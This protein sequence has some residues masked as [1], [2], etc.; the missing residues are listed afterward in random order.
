MCVFERVCVFENQLSAQ[1]PFFF[2]VLLSYYNCFILYIIYRTSNSRFLDV[3]FVCVCVCVCARLYTYTQWKPLPPR[4]WSP[5]ASCRLMP[6]AGQRFLSRPRSLTL[7]V[8]PEAPIHSFNPSSLRAGQ[9]DARRG[10]NTVT[11]LHHGAS[12]D[13]P[14]PPLTGE[15]MATGAAGTGDNTLDWWC[16]VRPLK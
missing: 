16:S 9:R 10:E 13:A 11:V 7:N 8:P 15:K 5:H 2:S 3:R 4:A 6:P 1:E 14:P 12:N